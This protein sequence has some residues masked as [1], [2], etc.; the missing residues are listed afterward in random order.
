[1]NKE[2]AR[3]VVEFIKLYD[4]DKDGKPLHA[5]VPGHGAQYY[6]V[7]M[8]RRPFKLDSAATIRCRCI[9]PDLGESC[10]GNSHGVCYHSVGAVIRAAEKMGCT[11]ALCDSLEGAWTVAAIGGTVMC[12][13]SV[14]SN[15]E[16]FAVYRKKEVDKVK[17]AE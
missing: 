5:L 17:K 10:K 15:K 1:M 13:R 6:Q 8:D 7:E 16:I 9:N 3:R 4:F 2:S 12:I 14:Q 11:I